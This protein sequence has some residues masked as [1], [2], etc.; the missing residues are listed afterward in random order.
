MYA[1]FEN[2]GLYEVFDDKEEAKACAAKFRELHR[3]EG[4]KPNAHVHKMT[5][6]EEEMFG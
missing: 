5:K 6:A 4:W 2:D 1:V 3:E